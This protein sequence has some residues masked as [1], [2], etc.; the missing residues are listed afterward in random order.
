MENIENIKF[1][2]VLPEGVSETDACY[3]LDML[4]QSNI[5]GMG[6]VS[7]EIATMMDNAMGGALENVLGFLGKTI[8]FEPF[9]EFILKI[10]HPILVEIRSTIDEKG[11]LTVSF[12]GDASTKRGLKKII[13]AYEDFLKISNE[14]KAQFD[15]EFK[16][17]SITGEDEKTVSTFDAQGLTSHSALKAIE[18]HKEFLENCKLEIAVSSK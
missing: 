8:T 14:N 1:R 4:Q 9:L 15:V 10:V 6:S 17:S 13:E 3:Y 5:A 12:K 7:F 18:L 2:L 16:I 11:R